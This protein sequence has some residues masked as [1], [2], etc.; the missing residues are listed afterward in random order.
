MGR[1]MSRGGA[2]R[3]GRRG[4]K[5][6]TVAWNVHA[7]RPRRVRAGDSSSLRATRGAAPGGS[8]DRAALGRHDLRAVER[9]GQPCRTRSPGDAGNTGA[10]G[11]AAPAPGRHLDRLDARDPQGWFLLRAPRSTLAGG[12]PARHGRRSRSGRIARNRAITSTW[13]APSLCTAVPSSTSRSDLGLDDPGSADNLDRPVSP[14]DV[15]YVFYTS[16]STGQTEGRG[17]F[18]SQRA[19]QRV[20]LYEHAA[21]RLRGS[22]ESRPGAELQ[23]HGLHSVRRAPERRLCGAV[24]PPERRALVAVRRRAARARHGLPRG[25]VDLS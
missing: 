18:A 5:P 15:A 12:D 24:R 9:R 2:A 10:A 7:I 21:I 11:R 13:A 8:R 4:E 25:A 23:W 1:R 3:E 19:A 14:D 17:R 16:G 20:P 22:T 6:A